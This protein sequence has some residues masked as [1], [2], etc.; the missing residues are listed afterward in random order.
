MGKK[1]AASDLE[2]PDFALTDLQGMQVRL[3]D[4]CGKKHVVLVFNRGF[5]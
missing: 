1:L 5:M 3:S 2:A 4:Y